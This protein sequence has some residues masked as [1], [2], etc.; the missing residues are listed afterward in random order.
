MPDKPKPGTY[1]AITRSTE[2][3]HQAFRKSLNKLFFTKE[4]FIR[5]GPSVVFR[6][7]HEVLD[8]L[9]K[10]EKKNGS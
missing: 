4:E 1:G 10:E 9:M 6:K 5:E 8:E 7:A 2:E 3:E